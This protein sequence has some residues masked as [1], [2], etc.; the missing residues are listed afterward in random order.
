MKSIMR[1]ALFLITLTFLSVPPGF[2]QTEKQSVGN[3]DE[4][5]LSRVKTEELTRAEAQ[6]IQA[7]LSELLEK[8]KNGNL[9]EKQAALKQISNSRDRRAI[10]PVLDLINN[11]TDLKSLS[12]FYV[13][14]AL[15][16]SLK[17]DPVF[18]KND[19]KIII[20]KMKEFLTGNNK[21]K[22]AVYILYRLDDLKTVTPYYQRW[23]ENNEWYE[24]NSLYEYDFLKD[25]NYVDEKAKPILIKALNMTPEVSI[26][27][28]EA[29]ELLEQSGAS[30]DVQKLILSPIIKVLRDESQKDDLRDKALLILTKMKNDNVKKSLEDFSKSTKNRH[31]KYE[32]DSLLRDWNKE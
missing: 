28:A 10:G 30:M 22:N 8:L 29:M 9:E 3:E 16:S 18:Q 15:V 26:K 14:G 1:N 31:L 19:K 17:N 23:L 7:H 4:K 24:I 21:D 2:G 27:A 20:E 6:T 25:R 12:P 11:P 32:V 13:L 5:R